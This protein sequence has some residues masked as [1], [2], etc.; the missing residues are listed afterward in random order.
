MGDG[1]SNET[2]IPGTGAVAA[3]A[4]A[5]A[6]AEEQRGTLTVSGATPPA[7]A[8]ANTTSGDLQAFRDISRA[9][10]PKDLKHE[11]VQKLWLDKMERLIAQ[12]EKLSAYEA[13][14]HELDRDN[15]LLKEQLKKR[16][17]IDLL[18]SAGVAL[19]LAMATTGATMWNPSAPGF[20]IVLVALGLGLLV[21]GVV[22]RVKLL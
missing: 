6:V 16:G 10:S 8:S 21:A 19:G 13:R 18:W 3:A 4:S 14:F 20:A 17:A 5:P 2:I 12:N 9:L 7:A 1:G 15:G 11:G 22:A